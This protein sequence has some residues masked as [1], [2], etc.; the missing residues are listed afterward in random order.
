MGEFLTN[1]T[2]RKVYPGKTG[3]SEYGP[4]QVWNFY[5]EGHEKLKLNYF[6]GEEK[7]IPVEGA[8]LKLIEYDIVTKGGYT[9]NNVKQ[10]VL[11]VAKEKSDSPPGDYEPPGDPLPEMKHNGK[12]DA[13]KP[14]PKPTIDS[15]ITMYISY[16]KDIAVALIETGHW[17]I[18][19]NTVFRDIAEHVV[20]VG[21]E[22]YQKVNNG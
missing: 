22:M 15:S 10:F 14:S 8:A 7:P 11:A 18:N 6:S 5:L 2:I 19:E 16:S 1:V 4:W 21:L 9:N 12:I 3:E 17:V 20:T 13:P